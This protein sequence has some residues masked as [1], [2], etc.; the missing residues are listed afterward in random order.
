LATRFR[1]KHNDLQIP[2]QQFD[3]ESLKVP[4]STTSTCPAEQSGPE[5]L[6]ALAALKLSDRE[7]AALRRQGTVSAERRGN[8]TIYKLRFRM[9]GRQQMRYLG[10]HERL[11]NS[12]EAEL[13][14]L[15]RE[16]RLQRRRA[17]L[18]RAASNQ[19]KS[20]KLTLQ[21]LLESRGFHFHGLAVRKRRVSTST[22]HFAPFSLEGD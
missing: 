12:V 9:N 14:V 16:V 18:G 1:A 17:A 21:P 6:S 10:I 8:T 2:H 4:T 7:L 3:H 19:L 13:D 15:Q 20:A 5:R 22:E 11:A